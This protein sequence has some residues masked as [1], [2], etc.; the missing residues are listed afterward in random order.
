MR[1][2]EKAATWQLMLS[3]VIMLACAVVLSG[4]GDCG[5]EEEDPAYVQKCKEFVDVACTRLDSC[6]IQDEAQCRS[7]FF[8][9][10]DCK[11]IRDE[12]EFES[13]ISQ[14]QSAD[15]DTINGYLTA[16]PPECMEQVLF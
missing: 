3:V 4:F 9:C 15:C 14:W 11:G 13:C 7:E 16:L 10:D 8:D 5:G 6:S 12:T 1:V 2:P